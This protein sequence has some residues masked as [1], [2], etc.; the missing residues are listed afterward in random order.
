MPPDES[1]GI[2]IARDELYRLVWTGPMNKLA[3]SYGLTGPELKWL[4]N[5]HEIPTPRAG[6]WSRV[7]FGKAVQNTPLPRASDL[8]FEVVRF[9]RAP[10][11]TDGEHAPKLSYPVD[12]PELF[13]LIDFERD[14]KNRITVS[15]ELT[16]PH[17]AIRQTKAALAQSRDYDDR[18]D[19]S[20]PPRPAYNAEVLVAVRANSTSRAL[21]IMDAL[22]RALERR[23]HRIVSEKTPAISDRQEKSAV[24]LMLGEPFVFA[25]R[26]KARMV[27]LTEEDQK[28]REKLLA[29]AKV[30]YECS[31]MFELTVGGGW[32]VRRWYDTPKRRLEDELNRVVLDLIVLVEARRKWRH[33]LADA[34]G[35]R[36]AE[37]AEEQKREQL[38]QLEA[39]RFAELNRLAERW[40]A[41]RRFREFAEAVR[42]EAIRRHDTLATSEET[43]RWLEWVERCARAIDPLAADCSLP[44]LGE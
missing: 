23:G 39:S 32:P 40:D 34:D 16:N 2:T 15:P 43:A 24:C 21:R 29:P 14:P 30:R 18:H 12:D 27:P 17:P 35:I 13:P 10:A 26:E 8:S 33:E 7:K 38:R 6:H 22:F 36:Q 28:A 31:G 3:A 1:S 20:H 11:R 42:A 9:S 19:Q 44:G 25:P 4:C 37:A 5:K 41:A